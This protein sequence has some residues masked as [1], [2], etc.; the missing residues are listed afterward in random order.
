MVALDYTDLEN[1][2]ANSNLPTTCSLH[3]SKGAAVIPG[4]IVNKY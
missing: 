2:P 4:G 3:Y 1:L